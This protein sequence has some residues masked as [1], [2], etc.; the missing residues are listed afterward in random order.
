MA[1]G[2]GTRLWPMSRNT[3]PK[4]LLP[5]VRR[6]GAAPG[7]P[8]ISLLEMS[9]GRL[10]GLVPPERRYICTGEQYRSAVLASLPAF[11]EAQILGEPA[12]R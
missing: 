1:G 2:A 3:Q 6:A 10:D 4:Q 5:L 12:A 9:A 8:A 11:S 7:S